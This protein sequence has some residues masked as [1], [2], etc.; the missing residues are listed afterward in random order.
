MEKEEE[1]KEGGDTP[2]GLSPSGLLW[3]TPEARRSLWLHPLPQAALAKAQELQLPKKAGESFL[4]FS[5]PLQSSSRHGRAWQEAAQGGAA[6]RQS[7]SRPRAFASS[8]PKICLGQPLNICR[9]APLAPH[10]LFRPSHPSP[11]RQLH[12]FFPATSSSSS[13]QPCRASPFPCPP[14][15]GCS[16]SWRGCNLNLLLQLQNQDLGDTMLELLLNSSRGL[17]RAPAWQRD[18]P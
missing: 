6:R 14:T 2:F 10:L 18:G 16:E 17:H 8:S 7:S 15:A 11:G 9:A 13:I 1:E 12:W 3:G 4:L 5:S